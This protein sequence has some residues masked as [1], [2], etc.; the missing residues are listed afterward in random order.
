MGLI[1]ELLEN[2]KDG[3][4]RRLLYRAVHIGG[5]VVIVGLTLFLAGLTWRMFNRAEIEV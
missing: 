1:S 4:L 3:A 2:D 5:Y